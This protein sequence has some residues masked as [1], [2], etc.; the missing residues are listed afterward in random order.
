MLI[1]LCSACSWF[2]RWDFH[3]LWGGVEVEGWEL[4]IESNDKFLMKHKCLS[5]YLS[6]DL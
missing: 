3:I 1:V 2:W 5:F 6:V 4:A